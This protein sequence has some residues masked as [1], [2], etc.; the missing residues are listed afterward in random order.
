MIVGIVA[1][2]TVLFFGGTQEYFFIEKFEKG[3]KKHVVEKDR[4]KEILLDLK[5]TKSMIKAFNK[6]R[7]GK[8]SEFLSLNLD[9]NVSRDVLDE[10]FDDRVEER[11]VFQ[12]KMIKQRVEI[13]AKFEDEE[14]QKIIKLS[15]ESVEK[16]MAKIA[17]KGADDPFK[18][19]IKTINNTI[20][21]QSKNAEALSIIQNFQERYALLLEKVNSVNSL[22]NSLLNNKNSSEKEFQELADNMNQHRE[23]AYQSFIDLHFDMKEITNEAEWTKVM[24]TINK[25]II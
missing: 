18:A 8:L 10:F 7:K 9:R 23:T 22:E 1:L 6:K 21:D 14:W 12:K 20:S 25:V 19:V 15:D 16:K 3:V 11:K 24:K 4:S 17:K 5:E 13:V 2:F